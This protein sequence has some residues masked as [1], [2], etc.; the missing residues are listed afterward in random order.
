VVWLAHSSDGIFWQQLEPPEEVES[1]SESSKKQE[2][3]K[4]KPAIIA[5][6]NLSGFLADC[7][8]EGE[9]LRAIMDRLIDWVA[10]H[11]KLDASEGTARSAIGL[12]IEN[13]K[14][15]KAKKLYSK[16]PNA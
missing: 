14:L 7:P 4:S 15:K 3:K 5:S 16:G 8:A 1:K 12:C 11:L 6:S 9:G 2:E 10:E 13:G